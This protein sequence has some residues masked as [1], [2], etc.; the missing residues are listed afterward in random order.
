M[1][2]DIQ[3]IQSRHDQVL[4][5]IIKSV[6]AEFDADGEGFGPS[7]SEVTCMS[8]HYHDDNRSLYFVATVDGQVVGGCGIMAFNK[9]LE[10]C[11]LR[12]LFLLPEAR[13]NGIGRALTIRSLAYAK[14]RAYKQCYLDTLSIMKSARVLYESLGFNYLDSPLDG[15]EHTACDVWM[16]KKL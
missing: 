10:V 3:P 8:R 16:I 13:G 2:F 4:C 14:S 5:R 1:L 6:G 15:V 7:D 9:N 12:K 11:E